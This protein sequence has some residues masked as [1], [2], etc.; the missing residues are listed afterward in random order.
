MLTEVEKQENLLKWIKALESGTYT[1]TIGTMRDCEGFCTVG[2]AIDLFV[3]NPWYRQ[4]EKDVWKSFGFAFDAAL[5]FLPKVPKIKVR[6]WQQSHFEAGGQ[7]LTS[8]IFELNDTR[9]ESVSP[10]DRP[11]DLLQAWANGW[12]LEVGE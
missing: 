5:T 4:D 7:P 3:P 6:F 2:V 10:F 11:L 12:D 1:P 8:T 9:V